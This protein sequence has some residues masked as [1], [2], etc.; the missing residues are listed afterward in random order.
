MEDNIQECRKRLLKITWKKSKKKYKTEFYYKNICK[1][2]ENHIR[3]E[4]G[5]T[6]DFSFQKI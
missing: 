1:L 4:D 3:C 2:L 5:L 6:Y